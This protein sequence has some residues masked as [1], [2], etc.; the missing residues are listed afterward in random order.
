MMALP[1]QRDA[2]REPF[3]RTAKSDRIARIGIFGTA[4]LVF[5]MLAWGH[6]G[7][8]ALIFP[9]AATAPQQ[10]AIAG[11]Y[12]V[13]FTANSGQL[14]TTGANAITFTL[15]DAMG[16][17]IDGATVQVQPVMTTMAMPNPSYS[18]TSLNDGRYVLHPTFSMA[19]DWRL[20]LTI[21]QVGQSP[22]HTSFLVSVHWNN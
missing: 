11:S 9:P 4:A 1:L 20:D 16:H 22:A 10:V 2:A 6:L 14:T 3:Q 5:A 21:T 8:G 15:H 13:I 18:M 7:L 12:H 17:A 19:G